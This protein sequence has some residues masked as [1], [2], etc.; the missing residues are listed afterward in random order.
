MFRYGGPSWQGTG[1]TTGL[2]TPP[3]IDLDQG[4]RTIGVVTINGTPMC[5]RTGFDTPYAEG[6]NRIQWSKPTRTPLNITKIAEVGSTGGSTAASTTGSTAART[7]PRMSERGLWELLKKIKTLKNIP[8]A[9][10]NSLKARLPYLTG[11]VGMPA[12]YGTIAWLLQNALEEAGMEKGAIS[13]RID[14]DPM[15]AGARELSIPGI[16]DSVS[17]S[18]V[19]DPF[20]GRVER[21]E[22][23]APIPPE[24][25]TGLDIEGV[26]K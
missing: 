5:N 19:P 11:T 23:T 3:R 12:A 4:G 17:I 2:D 1:I 22:T 24:A 21:Q 7:Y 26:L 14:M 25:V 16:D 20:L 9:I 8:P 6:Y 15:A 10:L 18:D 13:D